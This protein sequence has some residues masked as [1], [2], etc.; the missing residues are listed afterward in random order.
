M[1]TLYLRDLKNNQT[2][3]RKGVSYKPALGKRPKANFQRAILSDFPAFKGR[4]V[5]EHFEIYLSPGGPI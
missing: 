3:D 4:N 2:F 1:H 5:G